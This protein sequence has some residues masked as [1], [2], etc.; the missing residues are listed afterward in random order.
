MHY[1]EV[2]LSCVRCSAPLVERRVEGGHALGLCE[3]CGGAWMRA[4]EFLVMLREHQPRLALD[5]LP[6]LDDGT[7]RR[8]C[9]SC[10]A[11]MA[12]AWL[13]LMRL[14][15]CEAHGVWFDPGELDRALDGNT[16]PRE[17]APLFEP[18]APA[19]LIDTLKPR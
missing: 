11:K 12:I 14:D 19:R 10:G 3:Q 6:E 16:R 15:Q 9:P 2:S 7:P 8:P 5:E 4:D 13:E 18:R 1:R 17:L